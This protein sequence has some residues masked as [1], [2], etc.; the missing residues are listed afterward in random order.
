MSPADLVDDLELIRCRVVM[1]L[2]ALETERTATTI[3]AAHVL[4]NDVD[5]ALFE[6]IEKIRPAGSSP[7]AMAEAVN[8][9]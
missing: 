2:K 4:Q 8:A 5:N 1:I 7:L 6:L 9:D 3:D